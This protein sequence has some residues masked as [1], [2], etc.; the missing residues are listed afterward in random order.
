M[1]GHLLVPA[2]FIFIRGDFSDYWI[3]TDE[4]FEMA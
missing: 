2:T 1:S 4:P 3:Q